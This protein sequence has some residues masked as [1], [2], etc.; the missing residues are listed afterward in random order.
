M[1]RLWQAVVPRT[2]LPTGRCPTCLGWILNGKRQAVRR[3]WCPQVA[4]LFKTRVNLCH[5]H[6]RLILLRFVH[7]ACC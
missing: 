6:K 5:S 1:M 3:G 2:N 7:Q 4:L